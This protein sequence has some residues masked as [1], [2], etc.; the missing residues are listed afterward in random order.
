VK[1]SALYAPPS[2]PSSATGRTGHRPWTLW[3]GL[4]FALA[5]AFGIVSGARAGTATPPD[6]AANPWTQ[7]AQRW[8][9]QQL[10]GSRRSGPSLRPEV[11][12]GTLD[13]RLR[14]AP[15]GRVEPY[16]PPGTRLWGRSR[17][18]LRCIDGPVRWSVFLPVTVR[19]WGPAWVVRQP[20]APG[21]TLT[22]EDAELTEID[23]AESMVPVLPHAEDWVGAQATRALMPGQPLRQG[24]VRARALFAA[25]SQVKLVVEGE[26]FR[27]AAEG[28]AL[29]AG[30]AGQPVRVRLPGRRVVTGI[31]RD[32]ETVVLDR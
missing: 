1:F 7:D 13:P 24:M 31:V 21:S 5:L 15:C 26:G 23:W 3:L 16:L 11:E 18:G 20:V 8:I 22:Q 17:I 10:E 28:E 4:A 12:V 6:A 14:L 29:G 27:M 2:G 9:D 25:G 19:A 32:A 30:V